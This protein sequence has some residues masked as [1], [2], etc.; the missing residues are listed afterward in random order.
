MDLSMKCLLVD[1]LEE[2]LL[3]LSALL[4]E[5]DVELLLARSGNEALELLLSNEVALALVDVQMPGMDGFELAEL[6]RGSERTRNV[7]IIFVTAGSR[8]QQRV[9]QGYDLGAVDF[10][11]KP[12]E[13]HI[14][15]SKTNVFFELYRQRQQLRQQLTERTE[16]LRTNEMFMAIL[17][18]D[19]RNPLNSMLTGAELVRRLTGDEKVLK[20]V[21]RI[22]RSG[23]RMTEIIE[24]MLDLTRARLGGGITL[25]LGPC[26]LGEIAHQVA[27]E[28]QPEAPHP[29]VTVVQDGD[30]N[31][32]WDRGRLAQVVSNLIGNALSHGEATDPVRVRLDGTASER[33]C[34][35]VSNAGTMPGSVRARIFDPFSRS[36]E[37]RSSDNGLGLGLYIVE[38]IVNAHGGRVWIEDEVEGQTTFTLELPRSATPS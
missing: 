22:Q 6:M 20:A 32:V 38:Q 1:D 11:F 19:L 24:S 21:D 10:L 25:T 23:K 17:S 5:Q 29:G 9:F 31:G 14:L 7:P 3:V 2:N 26:D 30:L 8:D 37:R 12:I 15:Q 28:H 35:K 18:H 34:L 36:P 4:G 27:A 16:T 13:P 33:V